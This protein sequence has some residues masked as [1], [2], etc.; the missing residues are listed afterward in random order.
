MD[1]RARGDTVDGIGSG[2]DAQT[3]IR[4]DAG[5]KFLQAGVPDNMTVFA[6]LARKTAYRAAVR[7]MAEQH[8]AYRFLELDLPDGLVDK[9]RSSVLDAMSKYGHSGWRR[10]D[11]VSP[12]YGGFSLAFNPDHQDNLDPNV[13]SLGTPQNASD[14]FYYNRRARDLPA[15]NSYF[16]SYGFRRRTPA[17]RHS[18]LGGFLDAL[19]RPLVRSRVGIIYGERV[20]PTDESYRANSGWHRD[21][22]IYE[23]L[24]VNI[25]LQTDPNFVF[26]IEGEPPRHLEVGKAYS[27]DTHIPH[28]V[29]CSGP[30]KL[31]RIHLVLGV[32][33]WFDYDA[34]DDSWQANEFFGREHPFDLLLTGRIHPL[35]HA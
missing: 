23:N 14:K 31:E 13:S 9:L 3:T 28:R 7:R 20:D 24:R 35:L 29:Y 1:E 15:K 16:D 32:A 22:P 4:G 26:E 6:H 18:E 5:R 11:G 27:W 17:S 19:R 8:K 25:P 10:K 33:P 12:T 2:E 30:T 21:E 34:D